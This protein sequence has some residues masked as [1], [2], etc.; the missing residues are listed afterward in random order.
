MVQSNVAHLV[1]PRSTATAQDVANSHH[2]SSAG[3]GVA[4]AK[5]RSPRSFVILSLCGACAFLLILT[6]CLITALVLIGKHLSRT[7]L[8][9]S[10]AAAAATTTAALGGGGNNNYPAS[11]LAGRRGGLKLDTNNHHQQF[12]ANN[13]PLDHNNRTMSAETPLRIVS[14]VLAQLGWRLPKAVRPV[15][16]DLHIHPNFTTQRFAGRVAIQLQVN[17]PTDFIAVHANRLTVT[18]TQ[19]QRLVPS[20][21]GGDG[22]PQNVSI[23]QT[24]AQPQFEYWVTE[25][26]ERLPAGEYVLTLQYNGSLTDKIVGFYQSSYVDPVSKAKR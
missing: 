19:L 24:F 15:R 23:A 16:Y 18:D 17:E 12:A 8:E 10:A 13:Q 3:G 9:A 25:P 22:R 4:T 14:K 2:R 21:A 26:T 7:E 5:R 20:D 6:A 11:S 1:R